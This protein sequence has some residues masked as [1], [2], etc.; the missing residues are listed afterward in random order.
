[1]Y[2][3]CIPFTQYCCEVLFLPIPHCWPLTSLQCFCY[4]WEIHLGTLLLSKHRDLIRFQEFP[5][6]CSRIA[7]DARVFLVSNQ[8]QFL[9][10]SLFLTVLRNTILKNVSCSVQCPSVCIC[11]LFF[12]IFRVGLWFEGGRSEMKFHLSGV[13]TKQI[14]NISISEWRGGESKTVKF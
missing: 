2:S 1:M 8:W 9:R 5:F 11:L 14:F 6:L 12:F 13:H 3:S 4:N 7:F 10:L